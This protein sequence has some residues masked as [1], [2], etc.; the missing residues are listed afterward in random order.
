MKI[1]SLAVSSALSLSVAGSLALL[2][3]LQA[4]AQTSSSTAAQAPLQIGTA[5]WNVDGFDMPESVTI[6]MRRDRLI[7]SSIVGHPGQADGNGTLALL[8]PEGEILDAEWVTGLNAPKGMAIVGDILLVTDLTQL[9]EIDVNTGA[10]LR[11]IDVENAA[12]LND[13]TSDGTRAFISGFM[14]NNIWRYEDAE[15]S[16]WMNDPELHHPN[17]LL[18]EGDTLLVGS[19]G[20]GMRDD[21]TTASAG[22]LLAIDIRSKEIEIIASELGNLDGIAR[23]GDE[24]IVSDWVSGALFSVTPDGTPTQIAQLAAGLAD[25]AASGDTLYAPMMLDGAVLAY[26]K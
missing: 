13:I 8:S 23:L 22:D 16:L 7:V 17:G 19:W 25:I 4:E 5:T 14:T 11:S 21:F 24:I 9:H 15:L 20:Q 10:L 2:T 3:P 26:K 6:D 12:F 18:I 1:Q